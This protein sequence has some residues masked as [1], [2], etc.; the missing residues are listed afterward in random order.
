MFCIEL[1]NTFSEKELQDFRHLVHCRYFNTDA[2]V[3]TLF[4]ELCKSVLSKKTYDE[5]IQAML[6]RKIFPDVVVANEDLSKKQRNTLQSKINALKT[7]AEQFLMLEAQKEDDRRKYIFLYPKLLERKQYRLF[8]RHTNRDKK[9]LEDKAAKDASYYTQRYKIEAGIMDYLH[10][11]GKLTKEDN[12]EDLNYHLD[13]Y[14]LLTKLEHHLTTLSIKRVTA[15]KE[16]NLNAIKATDLLLEQAIYAKHPLVQLYLANIE[17]FD[18]PE[19]ATYIGLLTLLDEYNDVIPI[20]LLKYF[21][22]SALNYCMYQINAGQS[23]YLKNMFEL[24][25]IMDKKNLIIEDDFVPVDTLKNITISG[26]RIG[27]FDLAKQLLERYYPFIRRSVQDSVYNFNLGLIAFYN[28]DYELAHEKFIQTQPINTAYDIN[29]RVLILKCLYETGKE[30]NEPTVQAFRT[31]ESY[32]KN[33]KS[34][35]SRAKLSYKN[36]IRILIN[37]YRIR[38]RATKMSLTRLQGILEQQS[39]NSDKQWLLGKMGELG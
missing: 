30:Y 5:Q 34:L 20:R 36:F 19:D 26:C 27:A 1:L 14:Y 2:G 33:H 29:V 6:Y 28:K 38:H 35:T 23:A 8:S 17:L 24:Y 10:H 9:H 21:Y 3:T 25:Q 4:E 37:L 22:T 13:L 18:Q 15:R 39:V 16:Y 31:A 32:F 11:N 7:L 12:L